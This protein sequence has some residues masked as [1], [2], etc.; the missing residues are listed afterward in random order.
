MDRV[1]Q[2]YNYTNGWTLSVAVLYYIA[3][4]MYPSL[5]VVLLLYCCCIVAED[6]GKLNIS[7]FEAASRHQGVPGRQRVDLQSEDSG[8]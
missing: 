2:R 4:V 5:S 6:E 1:V 7:G 8:A 3:F